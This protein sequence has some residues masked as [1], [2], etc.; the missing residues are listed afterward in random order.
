[1]SE[2]NMDRR[3]DNLMPSAEQ[4]AELG[5]SLTPMGSPRA[6]NE[7][8]SIPE[9]WRTANV[10]D[11]VDTFG[12]VFLGLTIECAQCH[13]HPY[14]QWSK[15]DFELFTEFFTRIKTGQAPDAKPLHKATQCPPLDRTLEEEEYEEY[16]EEEYEDCGE[17]VT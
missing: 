6:G 14:D 16:E 1:M 10:V 4:I 9:E 5:K 8:G 7:D 2:R 17:D 15:R 11:R 12:T 13:K 3:Q